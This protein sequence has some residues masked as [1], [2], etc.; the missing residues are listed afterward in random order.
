MT[1]RTL[2]LL[3]LA[4]VQVLVMSVWFSASVIAPDLRT[5][6]SMG[7]TQS[8]LLTIAVQLGFVAGAVTSAAAALP[9]R[10][11]GGRLIGYA[12]CA[13]AMFNATLVLCTGPAPAIVLR[14]AT[15]VCL[16]AVYPVGMKL[17]SD[18]FDHGRGFAMGLMIAALAVGSNLPILVR[19]AGDLP[20][21][22]VV[23]TSTGLAACGAV[24]AFLTLGS[25]ATRSASATLSRTAL[26]GLFTDRRQRLVSIGYWG[27]MW[28]L[29][30]LWAWLPPYLAASAMTQ[31]LEVTGAEAFLCLGVFGAIGCLLAGW[32]SS[33]HGPVAVARTA[34]V[35]SGCCCVLSPVLF[36]TSTLLLLPFACLWGAAVIADSGQFSTALT[37]VASPERVGSSLTAQTAIGYLITNITLWSVPMAS[38]LIGE[39]FSLLVL[40]AGPLAG[41]VALSRLPR[42]HQGGLR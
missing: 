34:L 28:E 21:R 8:A 20:W 30:A 4:I 3:A 9:D 13:A 26:V 14:F 37:R 40:G 2:R 29:Y 27:H 24:L 19:G 36:G 10:V 31:G 41:V 11:G 33:R 25:S 7:A 39:R 32:L 16:A 1:R 5:T 12:A 38:Q 15:G 23:L 42:V 17:V 18:W 35:T 22:P 6:W